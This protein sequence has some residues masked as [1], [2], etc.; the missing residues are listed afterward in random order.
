[1]RF[2][3]RNT[4]LIALGA[5][6]SDSTLKNAEAIRAAL[7]EIESA[8]EADVQASGLWRTP[9]FPQ[10]AGPDFANACA[11]VECAL[12]PGA[13]LD[14]LHDIEARMG[15]VRTRRGGA[16]V[17]DLDL[18][19][20]GALILPDRETVE[21]WMM[22]APGDQQRLAPDRLILPHPRLHERAFVLVPLAQIAPDW[23]HPLLGRSVQAM[24]DALDPADLAEIRPI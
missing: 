23:V 14:R 12:S 2:A 1:M 10:G 3:N 24:R 17:I 9:A 19:G 16:R 7:N 20:A 6:E 11:R 13:M 21:R 8:C 4:F 22:L 18:L 15:R 5:N